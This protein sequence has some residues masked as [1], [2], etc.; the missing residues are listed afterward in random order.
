[1]ASNPDEIMIDARKTE[2]Y[3]IVCLPADCDGKTNASV[4]VTVDT[5]ASGNVMHLRVFERLYP[6]QIN[7]NGEPTGWKPVALNSL[8]IMECKF[9]NIVLCYNR[10][11]TDRVKTTI[12]N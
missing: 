11:N 1:M 3:T 7:L 2:A 8:H 4:P 9:H 12:S 10:V 6:K 5:G